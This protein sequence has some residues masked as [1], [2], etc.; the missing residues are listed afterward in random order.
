VALFHDVADI[1]GPWEPSQQKGKKEKKKKRRSYQK[2][3]LF[4]FYVVSHDLATVLMALGKKGKNGRT[5]KERKKKKKKKKE[6]EGKEERAGPSLPLLSV[7]RFSLSLRTGAA[8]G[9]EGKK[10][11]SA[12]SLASFARVCVGMQGPA[13]RAQKKENT[14]QKKEKAIGPALKRYLR[15]VSF[16]RACGRRKRP[17][18]QKKRKKKKETEDKIGGFLL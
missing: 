15:A 6:E 7:L 12:R 3:A 16:H 4:L 1:V 5:G 9:R 11:G 18:D 10:K 14:S 13:Y 17:T 2:C 8:R